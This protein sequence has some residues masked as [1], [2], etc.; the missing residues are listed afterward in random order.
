MNIVSVLV[1]CNGRSYRVID[2]LRSLVGGGRGADRISSEQV[3][4]RKV[5]NLARSLEVAPAPAPQPT[6]LGTSGNVLIFSDNPA[7]APAP[8]SG[9]CENSQG[10]YAAPPSQPT[11]QEGK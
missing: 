10:H 6:Y 9:I 8:Q 11:S 7:A 2:N 3:I 4:G 5:L 1:E